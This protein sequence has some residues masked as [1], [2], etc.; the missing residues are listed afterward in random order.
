VYLFKT[1]INILIGLSGP[2]QT[3]QPLTFVTF[4]NGMFKNTALGGGLMY[5]PLLRDGADGG[6]DK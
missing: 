1:E 2:N 5:S 4:R 3:E 6:G